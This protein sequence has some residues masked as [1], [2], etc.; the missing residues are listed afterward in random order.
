MIKKEKGG[1]AM[2]TIFENRYRFSDKMMNEYVYGVLMKKTI[3]YG[4]II[5]IAGIAVF[6]WS[7]VR[8]NI[9]FTGI[10][11]AVIFIVAA[12]L[13]FAPKLTKRELKRNIYTMHKGEQKETIVKFSDRIYMKEG[14]LTMTVDYT[15][16]RKIIDMKT[17]IVLYMGSNSGVILSKNGFECSDIDDFMEFIKE[18]CINVK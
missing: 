14:E 13:V 8:G 12:T 10:Y 7:I 11:G 3:I 6:A 5:L 1:Q 15:Q 4:I 9:L 16:I 17:S 18:K 2:D